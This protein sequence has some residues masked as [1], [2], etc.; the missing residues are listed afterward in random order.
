MIVTEGAKLPKKAF[1]SVPTH[2]SEAE[3]P[4]E[5]IVAK[6]CDD[7]SRDL[8]VSR[9][10]QWRCN[11]IASKNAG[12]VANYFR[13]KKLDYPAMVFQLTNEICVEGLSLC[14]E[15]IPAPKSPKRCDR[16]LAVAWD[17]QD[18]LVRRKGHA[19]Y[20]DKSHVWSLLDSSCSDL[21]FRFAPGLAAKLEASCDELIEESDEV[22]ADFL[23]KA[24]LPR[25]KSK[26]KTTDS[27]LTENFVRH[28][29]A[30][31]EGV[32]EA[33]SRNRPSWDIDKGLRSPWKLKPDDEKIHDEL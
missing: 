6:A 32:M 2:A 3:I 30:K 19:E 14:D 27:R 22:I 28:V 29:C 8:K 24:Q 26:K 11:E 33:C 13:Q 7:S 9:W 17:F 16:C 31:G 5:K 23:L 21:Q 4:L 18:R 1:G 20:M 15:P 12:F 25:K 10:I